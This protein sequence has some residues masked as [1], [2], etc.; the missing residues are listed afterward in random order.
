MAT[1]RPLLAKILIQVGADEPKEIGTIEIPIEVSV[2]TMTGAGITMNI[3]ATDDPKETA[4]AIQRRMNAL[5][6]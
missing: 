6:I 1:I 4:E 2:P 3:N 5:G